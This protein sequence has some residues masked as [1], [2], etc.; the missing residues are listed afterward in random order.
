METPF[1]ALD[2]GHGVPTHAF[3]GVR[4]D[5]RGGSLDT[6]SG[7]VRHGAETTPV[8]D[9]GMR[10]LGSA[11][12]MRYG[13]D[14][15]GV[16][17]GGDSGGLA[18]S[19]GNR[20]STVAAE[21][22]MG[23][24]GVAGGA[25][26]FRGAAPYA[27]GLDMG[28]GHAK[29]PVDEGIVVGS[30]SS[31]GSR[32]AGNV[33]LF[34]AVGGMGA[35]LIVWMTMYFLMVAMP[36]GREVVEQNLMRSM[37][38]LGGHERVL[39]TGDLAYVETGLGGRI[40]HTDVGEIV[41][42]PLRGGGQVSRW[43]SIGLGSAPGTA[44]GQE[45]P[46]AVQAKVTMSRYVQQLRD[47]QDPAKKEAVKKE[48][49]A[50]P[51][52][53]SGRRISGG[54]AALQMGTAYSNIHGD[55]QAEAKET[56]DNGLRV[57]SP[58]LEYVKSLI[59]DR[60]EAAEKKAAEEAAKAVRAEAVE[61]VAEAVEKE[62]EAGEV[63]E[64]TLGEAVEKGSKAHDDAEAGK[65]NHKVEEVAV[66]APV[67]AVAKADS[68]VSEAAR[69]GS[70]SPV[71][72]PLHLPRPYTPTRYMYV[73]AHG[74]LNSKRYITADAVANARLLNATL[75][76]PQWQTHGFWQSETSFGDLFDVAYFK[77]AFKGEV[78]IID[79]EELPSE[80]RE[81]ITKA[82]KL[83]PPMPGANLRFMNETFLESVIKP[84]LEAEVPEGGLFRLVPSL[85]TFQSYPAGIHQ[86]Q[87]KA[88]MVGLKFLPHIVDI[89][90]RVR[91]QLGDNYVAVHIRREKDIVLRSGCF[92]D[93]AADRA[94]LREV[95][96]AKGEE[97]ADDMI[98]KKPDRATRC[99]MSTH[100]ATDFLSL[101]AASPD[102]PEPLRSPK[103][104]A[105]FKAYVVGGEPYGGDDTTHMGETF[106]AGV[107]RNSDLIP[108]EEMS[109]LLEAPDLLAA[110]DYLVS[111]DST[112][113]VS[114]AGNFDTFVWGMRHYFG[115]PNLNADRH[116][117]SYDTETIVRTQ[118][119]K[120]KYALG[121]KPMAKQ[122][123]RDAYSNPEL[124]CSFDNGKGGQADYRHL[125]EPD[126]FSGATST[127]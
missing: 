20:R 125:V 61:D 89:A 117:T 68:R 34:R 38:R 101:V 18:V 23:R 52:E 15:R 80:L 10:R 55:A 39:N 62:A 28:A 7:R 83:T 30:N 73:E 72:M 122:F 3:G 107:F 87:C 26:S 114:A 13:D 1:P 111:L 56:D 12:S 11:M 99:P 90:K 22:G 25:V 118:T 64:E 88:N 53:L 57:D 71:L 100:N 43:G 85:G 105:Q 32:A 76:L 19:L 102:A 9:H 51:S 69:D 108:A 58:M 65:S 66:P 27:S 41:H 92:V 54:D 115:R 120:G 70:V 46:S 94:W 93:E 14:G 104:P 79:L 40:V 49:E 86:L 67:P 48:K 121:F 36:L 44:L 84:H 95:W 119:D 106:Q 33:T 31:H 45:Q 6:Q 78:D 103:W 60:K 37:A 127:A 113:Y 17:Y 74:G 126:P 91:A 75:V 2:S 59:K 81:G 97:A 47:E 16:G 35:L 82:P 77:A 50:Q 112:V 63:A 8:G 124:Y 116:P 4:G 42:V 96:G 123:T 109:V 98:A 24:R 110:I 29:R 5:P 21:V